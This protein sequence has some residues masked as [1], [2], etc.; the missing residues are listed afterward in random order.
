MAEWYSVDD[1]DAVERLQS[2]WQDAPVENLEVLGMLL[3][4]A[5]E[6]VIA[7]APAPDPDAVTVVDGYVIAGEPL[8]A[9]YVLAQLMQ[10]RN[11]LNAGTVTSEGNFGEGGFTFTPRP[12]DKTIKQI[13]RPADG[14]PHVR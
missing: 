13:I 12:M 5:R 2:A 9:R 6:Q 4:T 14:K 10:T 7:Y 8:P 1:A 3:E 11:L